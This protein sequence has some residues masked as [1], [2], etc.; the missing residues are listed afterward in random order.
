MST[1][2]S[3]TITKAGKRGRADYSEKPSESV[4]VAT[5]AAAAPGP[6]TA[7]LARVRYAQGVTLNLGNYESQRID[8]ELAVPCRP[9]IDAIEA[10]YAFAQEW[11]DGKL[12]EEVEA[13]RG[14][15]K[16]KATEKDGADKG[17]KDDEDIPF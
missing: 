2:A 12:A 3:G 14:G 8:V 6:T 7:A 9:G 5:P 4:P 1:T 11:V 17:G 15:G 13:A 10:A 16:E